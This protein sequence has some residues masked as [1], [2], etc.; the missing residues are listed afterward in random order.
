M[1]GSGWL[2]LFQERGW[3]GPNGGRG[4]NTLGLILGPISFVSDEAERNR[5]ANM[6]TF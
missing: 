6:M 2:L 5:T 4:K 3:L 1:A